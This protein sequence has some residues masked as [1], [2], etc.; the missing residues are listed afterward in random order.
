MRVTIKDVARE[1]GVSIST[2]SNALN[3]VDVL[4]PSTKAHILEVAEKLHYIPNLNGRNLKAHQTKVLGLFVAFAG[5]HY[6]GALADYMAREC[7]QHGYELHIFVTEKE[8]SIMRNLMGQRVDGAVLL[9]SPLSEKQEEDIQTAGIPL[10]F[11]NRKIHGK[12]RASVCF[13]S[14]QAGKMAAELFLE[15]GIERFGLVEG[16]PC[17]DGWE[18]SR[19]YRETLKE[20]NIELPDKFVWYGDFNRMIASDAMEKY[21][22]EQASSVS[23]SLPQAIFA[24]NDLSAIGIMEVFEKHRIEVPRTIKI[25]GCDDIAL[26]RYTRPALSSIRTNF[27]EQGVMAVK[28]LVRMLTSDEEGEEI[29]LDCSIIKRDTV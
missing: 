3:G 19:G 11:L 8:D 9:G 2:V 13:D 18:R 27:E 22:K 10:V 5:G 25:L 20:H 26:C 12:K 4:Q 7:R 14:Y 15:K 23:V 29:T 17:F 24:A 16:S 21:L 6:I 1:A 28:C